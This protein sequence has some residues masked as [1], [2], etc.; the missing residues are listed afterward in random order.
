M[1]VCV[2]KVFFLYN[3]F[4][5]SPS[6]SYPHACRALTFTPSLDT[7][8]GRKDGDCSVSLWSYYSS[9][10]TIK[11]C[12]TLKLIPSLKMVILITSSFIS[13]NQPETNQHQP[14]SL[15]HT[16]AHIIKKNFQ[17][18]KLIQAFYIVSFTKNPP[19]LLQIYYTHG[20]S[21]T[22]S[23]PLA[24]PPSPVLPSRQ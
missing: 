6:T 7:G 21:P 24:S 23:K 18:A 4:L 12:S 8:R 2:C 11:H 14:T 10:H 5:L 9:L 1:C 3:L 15:S 19:T 16:R 13:T 17:T 20:I 22:V